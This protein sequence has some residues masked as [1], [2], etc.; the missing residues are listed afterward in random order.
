[1]KKDRRGQFSPRFL[2]ATRSIVNYG[3]K[4]DLLL[5]LVS[6]S[7]K[8]LSLSIDLPGELKAKQDWSTFVFPLW[9]LDHSAETTFTRSSCYM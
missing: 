1:M 5:Q 4:L 8:A 6:Y 3:M 7:F 2:A 9:T